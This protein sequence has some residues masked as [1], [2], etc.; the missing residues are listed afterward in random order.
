MNLINALEASGMN[1]IIIDEDTDFETLSLPMTNIDF[2]TDLMTYNP[3][4]CLAQVFIIEAI[5]R[6]AKEVMS[7]EPWP[8][9]VIISFEAWKACAT[10]IHKKIEAR[11]K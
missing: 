3:A 1:P 2:V 11:N 7:A 6:Y 9:D 8:D 4:G 10:H 5:D